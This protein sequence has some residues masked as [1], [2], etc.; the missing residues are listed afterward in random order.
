MRATLRLSSPAWLAQPSSTSS[1]AAQSTEG[2]APCRARIGCA[3][4]SSARTSSARRRSGRSACGRNRRCMLQSWSRSWFCFPSFR[5]PCDHHAARR[6]VSN[7][8]VSTNGTLL[9]HARASRAR[10][11]KPRPSSARRRSSGAG[12][13]LSSPE[14]AANSSSRSAICA[15]PDLVGVE[16]RAAAPDRPA[17][18]VDPDHVDVAGAGGDTL[19]EDARALVDHRDRSGARRSPPAGSAR[20]A[21]PSCAET[22][23]ISRSTC[24]VRLRQPVR[25]QDR[26]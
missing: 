26:R 9:A 23:A 21:T 7:R 19:V 2:C 20:R 25:P 10:E 3:A 16:H 14:R 8:R 13:R 5:R 1:S 6:R 4:R 17:V 24:R 12:R 11:T 22:S 18:A 15:R